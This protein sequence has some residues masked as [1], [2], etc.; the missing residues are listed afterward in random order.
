VVAEGVAVVARLLR[1]DGNGGIAF[2][3]AF[4][5]TFVA[6]HGLAGEPGD[7]DEI[8]CS[9]MVSDALGSTGV[10]VVGTSGIVRVVGAVG[11][12]SRHG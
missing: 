3:V 6:G 10:C 11:I 8:A 12:L 7:A 5:E 9:G 1:A 4:A 2:I